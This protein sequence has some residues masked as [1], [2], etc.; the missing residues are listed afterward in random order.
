MKVS[1]AKRCKEAGI[2][3][4]TALKRRRLGWPEGD[5]LV[6][7]RAPNFGDNKARPTKA[8][9]PWRRS[10]GCVGHRAELSALALRK[11]AKSERS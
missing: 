11:L 7:P 10:P 5:L 4:A 1:L 9:H 3:Y 8:T 2:T 6:I